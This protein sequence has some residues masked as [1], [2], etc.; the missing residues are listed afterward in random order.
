[1]T[2]NRAQLLRRR[3]AQRRAAPAA[4][5]AAAAP[6]R[7]E[8]LVEAFAAVAAQ[9]PDRTAVQ[10]GLRSWT[11][12]QLDETAD[13]LAA[14]LRAVTADP[15]RPVGILLERSAWM[16]AAALAVVRTGSSYVPL[17]PDSPPA[18][19]EMIVE[20]AEPAAL[21]TSRSLTGIAPGGVPAVVVGEPL[22]EATGTADQTMID[23][24]TR[25]YIIFTS[26][27]TGRPKGVQ[28]SHGN[29]LSLLAAGEGEFHF[30]PDDVWTLFHSFSFDFSVW[31][32][33]GALLHGG[34]LVVV[35]APTA[36]DPA[37]LR[38]LLRD[39]RVTVLC[40]TPSAFT[41]LITEDTRFAD[42]LPLR[43][44]IF[45]GETLHFSDLAAWFAK[46]GDESPRL[47]NGYGITETTILSSFH[48][49]TEDQ[50]SLRESLIGWPISG[51][52]FVLLD[53]AR[54]PVPAGE[55][56]EL[57]VTGP[58]VS[59]G[60]LNR[61]E[62]NE[63][64]F[65]DLPGGQ[66]RGYLSGDL[67]RLTSAGAFA[68]H[69]RKDDQ[70]K[71]RGY[72]IELG[73]I[74]QA[75]R[76]V[77]QVTEAAVVVRDLPGRGDSLIAYVVG[78]GGA[79][80]SVE[81]LHEALAVT[82]PGYMIPRLFIPLERLPLTANGKS[83]RKAL[84]D[85]GTAAALTL[86]AGPERDPADAVEGRILQIITELLHLDRADP[87]AG[88]FDLGGHSLLAT[89]LLAA[90]RSAF[91][92][93]VP[94]REFLREPTARALAAA[95]RDRQAE[96]SRHRSGGVSL[97]KAPRD[98]YQPATDA[99]RRLYFLSELQPDSAAYHLHS[100]LLLEGGLNVQALQRAFSVVVERHA[101]LRTVLR[102][103]NG[104]LVQVIQPPAP[105]LLQ[106][107]QL[108]RM[109]GEDWRESIDRWAHR[110]S[111]RPFD[112]GKDPMLR[113]R[114][115]EVAPGL[116]VLFVTAHHIAA[117]GWSIALLSRELKA[118]YGHFRSNPDAPM[119]LAP[120]PYTYA[121]YAYSMHRWLESPAAETDLVYWEQRLASLP[122]VHRLP[123]DHPRPAR[124]N[125]ADT[126]TT[127]LTGPVTETIRH[128][129]RDENVTLFTFLQAA[130]S[131]LLAR[132]SGT[133]DIVI[134]CAVAGRP[135]SE[136]D[137]VI[138]MFVNT[139]VLRTRLEGATTFRALL[140]RVHEQTTRDLEHQ[141][142]PLASLLRRL[143]PPHHP[144]H[145]PL[146]QMMLVLQNN[147]PPVLDFDGLDVTSVR[148]PELGAQ[149]ELMLDA[150]EDDGEL[151]LRW[152]YHTGLFRRGTIADLAD[153]FG[154]MLTRF[155]SSAEA[156]TQPLNN[157]GPSTPPARTGAP[158]R[159]HA[160]VRLRRNGA[161]RPPVFALPG[162][163]GMGESFAQLSAHFQD[164]S[165][166]AVSTADLVRSLAGRP[167]A[168]DLAAS[169]ARVI[170]GAS[171]GPVHLVGHS[172]GGCLALYVAEQLRDRGVPVAGL[173]LL[174]ALDPAAMT[175]A[176]SGGHDDQFL[177]FLATLG[178]L[179]PDLARHQDT[180]LRQLLRTESTTS[181]L[182]RVENIIGPHA[183]GFFDGGLTATFQT[184]RQMC[185]LRWPASRPA[186]YPTLLVR[187]TGTAGRPG[188]ADPS[189]W[190][191]HLPGT[192]QVEHID[193]SHEGMLRN[194]HARRLAELL[195]RFLGE[196][197]DAC[198]APRRD[199]AAR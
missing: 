174:D 133:D 2:E 49:V 13:R 149:A 92:V 171:G 160:L 126:V 47:L 154:S 7:A 120:L 145:A 192:L 11:Y 61:P 184:Y 188:A 77:A 91:D 170:A 82:L 164:R 15:G 26:G 138:G 99:Q 9:H 74:E 56:G 118:L 33:W 81:S 95:V 3:V 4:P 161:D 143:N 123:L 18:R 57:V 168:A 96:P 14:A 103:E 115:A 177:A 94:L 163:L 48:R 137:D 176:L 142:V 93:D 78:A 89:R 122:D 198:E 151:T 90:V 63:E 147:E 191:R 71:I 199:S 129:C 23:R 21:I 83:D 117:D 25:A 20:D 45:G 84:P 17:D 65:I 197:D 166:S 58:G 182:E 113:V 38:R 52:G 88:F 186:D 86:P 24:D 100:T 51:T 79:T 196:H 146:F 131:L 35:P 139:L 114:L 135:V 121:D 32:M 187:A 157:F 44:V 136:L 153:E 67:A 101:P 41:P 12:R 34:R 43:W 107:E 19:L 98:V 165:F 189:G 106:A 179:F 76:A 125:A 73:E 105:L 195:R 29:L 144:D 104:D 128:T 193:A 22:P 159:D 169:C 180:D 53:D 111:V 16:V 167:D 97:E 155:S 46:Y 60:Y 108:P 110:E 183:A 156:R 72:R 173:A 10:D 75:L 132:R 134:G 69:G 1:M 102:V 50:L 185:D 112:L 68:F 141:H 66:G 40:Q 87:E 85:P 5:A 64:R 190:A 130:F 54:T 70:V 152:R 6:R 28:V 148:S 80:L 37:T 194:P 181:I 59:L 116:H 178:G 62:L 158:G 162:V 175:K 31:E 150:V 8:H 55:I 127:T 42:R 39:E 27:T 36:Q 109:P 124:T 119:P 30:G 140:A 172:Y